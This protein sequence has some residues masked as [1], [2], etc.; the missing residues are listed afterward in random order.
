M[1]RVRDGEVGHHMTWAAFTDPAAFVAFHDAAC[2]DH[3]IPHPGRNGATGEVDPAAQWT[4]AYTNP[5]DDHGTIKAAVADE[6]VTTYGLTTTT[7]PVYF[8]ADGLPVP[9]PPTVPAW[10]WHKEPGDRLRTEITPHGEQD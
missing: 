3:G 5:V 4:T 10:E 2:A 8:D 6:D 9:D 7:A 1:G